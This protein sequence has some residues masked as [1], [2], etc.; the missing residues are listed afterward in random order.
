MTESPGFIYFRGRGKAAKTDDIYDG[1]SPDLIAYT[2]NTV[3]QDEIIDTLK[4][5]KVQELTPIEAM[6]ELYKLSQKAAGRG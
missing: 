5:L 1:G 2:A 4:N 6:N 3:M